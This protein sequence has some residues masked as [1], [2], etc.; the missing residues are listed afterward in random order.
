MPLSCSFVADPRARQGAIPRS[1]WLPRRKRWL[2]TVLSRSRSAT[3]SKKPANAFQWNDTN[4]A[5]EL[6]L[7]CRCRAT[8]FCLTL[9]PISLS[10][11][12]RGVTGLQFKFKDNPQ[13]LTL[14]NQQ[15][16]PSTEWRQHFRVAQ[17]Q[18]KGSSLSTN[19]NHR[20][21]FRSNLPFPRYKIEWLYC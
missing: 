15:Q 4:P 13:T 2:P 6:G 8:L 18:A 21:L 17:G 10:N 16:Q 12:S 14:N 9:L 5:N 7:N 19:Y 20:N 11:R 1:R 3:I